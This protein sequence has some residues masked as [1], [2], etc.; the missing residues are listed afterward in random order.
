MILTGSGNANR[1]SGIPVQTGTPTDTFTLNYEASTRRWVFAASGSPP[2]GAVGGGAA[3]AAGQVAFGVSPAT[4]GSEPGFAWNAAT[5]ELTVT[6]A[7]GNWERLF[8]SNTTANQGALVRF[9]NPTTNVDL[10]I[11]GS[12]N[13]GWLV[14][15]QNSVIGMAMSPTNRNI[16]IGQTVPVDDGVNRL[17]VSGSVGVTGSAGPNI[18][19]RS[20]DVGSSAQVAFLRQSDA[21]N[22]GSVGYNNTLDNIFLGNATARV[23][24]VTQSSNVLIGMDTEGNFRFDVG[25]SGSAGT[26]RIYDQGGSN[27]TQLIVRAATNQLST[28]LQ[29]WQNAAGTQVA[30]VLS[31]GTISA[32]GFTTASAIFNPSADMAADAGTGFSVLLRPNGGVERVRVSGTFIRTTNS[33]LYQFSSDSTSFG[34]PDTGW[35]R[36]AAGILEINNGTA[37]QFRDLALRNAFFSGAFITPTSTPASASATGAAGT[38]A[39]DTNYIYIC[40]AANTW[41]R[42]AIAT[43]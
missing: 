40:T 26:A 2:G 6:K 36:N 23:L 29:T 7:G 18:L 1:I 11:F 34:T 33:Q 24:S 30:A 28:N 38:W 42:V 16:I 13:S 27:P 22:R 20:T 9:T 39:W 19:V 15:R 37:G 4:L 31:T 5:T 43:W 32:P 21:A 10:G 25:A 3:I 8:L 35:S 12:P 41:K 14:F 17:Q